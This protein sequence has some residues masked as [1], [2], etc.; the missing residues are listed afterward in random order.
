[1]EI[2]NNSLE[3][4]FDF[5]II[6]NKPKNSSLYASEHAKDSVNKDLQD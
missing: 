3:G 5:N 4:P 2:H 1:M 6:D